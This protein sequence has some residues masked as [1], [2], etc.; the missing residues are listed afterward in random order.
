MNKKIK[1]ITILFIFLLLTIPVY[2]GIFIDFFLVGEFNL[3]VVLILI[4]GYLFLFG[5]GKIIEIYGYNTEIIEIM[6]KHDVINSFIE[7][8]NKLV[9]W[10]GFLIIMTIEELIFRYYLM[11]MFN[12]LYREKIIIIFISSLIFAVYHLH[13]W[14]SYKNLRIVSIFF[15]YS[16]CLG[17]YTGYLL[18]TLGIIP[19]IFVHYSLAIVSY[20]G[21][22]VRYFKERTK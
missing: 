6:K 1:Y 11:G 8:N 4:F 19:C 3:I 20:Y 15:C 18:F 5:L 13:T 21:I 16:L 14:F 12:H 22:F 2:F 9:R 7:N 10:L 17:L